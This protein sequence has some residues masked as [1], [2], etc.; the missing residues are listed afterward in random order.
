MNLKIIWSKIHTRSFAAI[1]SVTA[2]IVNALKGVLPVGKVFLIA[3]PNNWIRMNYDKIVGKGFFSGD[4]FTRIPFVPHEKQKIFTINADFRDT[5][6]KGINLYRVSEYNICVD[7]EIFPAKIS[8][9][10]ERHRAVIAEWFAVS[11]ECIDFFEKIVI[12]KKP[13]KI[14]ISQGHNFD[15]AIV[16]ALSCLHGFGV[17]AVENTFN[18]NKI[19][20]EDISG[21]TVNKNLAKNFYWKYRDFVTAAAAELYVS[22]YLE[23]IKQLKVGEHQT[24]LAAATK[25]D[26][27][28]VMFIGQVYTDSSVLFGINTFSCPVAIIDQLVD[29][30]LANDYHLIIKLH[31]KEA[32]GYNFLF[33]PYSNLTY[34]RITEQEGL[35]EK[36]TSGGFLLDKWLYDTYSLIDSAD[37]CVTVNSQA[38]LEALIKGKDV[39]VCGQGYYTGLGFTF[40]ALNR[41]CLS[42][43]LDMIVKQGVSVLNRDEINKFF[44]IISE[45]YFMT[46]NECCI[47]TLLQ[48]TQIGQHR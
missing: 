28:T 11:A 1:V 37:V 38:G 23:N 7:L 14:L 46:R 39:I 17:V 4:I 3:D 13:D 31:P 5:E 33:R 48:K 6:Y 8:F 27:K 35:L 25:S 45:K 42:S 44:Y 24:P 12:Q 2:P 21:I 41:M 34:R 16:R 43:F 15:A 30:C 47:E 29:Y 9:E 40:E 18:K 20:W 32:T 26:K 10:Y 22:E 19:V 36:I